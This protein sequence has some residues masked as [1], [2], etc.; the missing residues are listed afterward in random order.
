MSDDEQNFDQVIYVLSSY[1]K[2]LIYPQAGAGASHTIPVQCSALR[3]NGHVM[4]KGM[5]LYWA[6]SVLYR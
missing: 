5:F 1:G 4:L 3:K 2:T 6:S